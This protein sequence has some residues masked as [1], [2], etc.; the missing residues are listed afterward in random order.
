M[1]LTINEKI[2]FGAGD[3]AIAI[4]MMS[5]AMIITYFY[6]DVF[7]LKPVDL[8]ILLFSVRILDA[9]I[10]PVVGT[11][12]DRTNT[13]WG[14]YR[15][16]LLF[17][18][19]PFG[20]SIWLMFTT[21]DTDYS[22]K[23]LWAWATYVLLTLTYTLIAIPYVPLSAMYLGKNN[24][25][26][27]YQIAMGAMGI[28]ATCLCLYCFFSVR[29]RIYHPKPS[30]GMAAQFRLLIK[31]DQWLILGAVIAIIMFGGI[32]RNSV[33]AYYAKYYLNGGDAL[34]SPFLTS[35][36]IA[37]VL[38]MI[39]CTWLTRL[40]DKIKIFR[41]TQLLAFV[42]G[43]AMYFVQ[44]NS[45]VLA[46]TFYIVVTFLTDI[47][48]PI[49]WASIAESVDYG[50]MKTGQRVSGLAFGGILFFQK[51][52]MGLAGGFIGIALAYL[53]YQPGVEQTPQALWGICLLMTIFPAI[54]N[55]ITGLI[56][57]FYLIN[58]EF[59]EQIKARLQTAEE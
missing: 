54:L 38:A 53:D 12:T 1:K 35:G 56:M 50:E 5:L 34:I 31:N 55:L 44:P 58:N 43:G 11:M 9:V 21:P 4:V 3:M 51:F 18:S 39:A 13:R 24:V 32:I 6:T 33:A 14:K 30:L 16:G 59:Y 37:S 23:L 20:I 46:F 40:Y 15:P 42:V 48:L 28:L 49:Y 47:Q 2:G 25:K 41:Y 7:G 19:I 26:L 27:G 52:G 8:G 10:D 22:V 36:V 57:R 17:M 29:E 45:I